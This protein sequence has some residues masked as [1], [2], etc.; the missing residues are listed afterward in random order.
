MSDLYIRLRIPAVRRLL[1]A[2]LADAAMIALAVL[3]VLPPRLPSP[4]FR[5]DWAH[6]Y[7]VPFSVYIFCSC[8]SLT[9]AGRGLFSACLRF[10]ALASLGPSTLATLLLAE[11]AGMVLGWDNVIHIGDDVA[12]FLTF[13]FLSFAL[14]VVWRLHL[15]ETINR[16]MVTVAG[17]IRV[18]NSQTGHATPDEERGDAKGV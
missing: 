1:P 18:G 9:S 13:V 10:P 15:E 12:N 11:F 6:A 2:L 17:Y 7:A 5:L 8:D 3:T 14:G 16:A 4:G